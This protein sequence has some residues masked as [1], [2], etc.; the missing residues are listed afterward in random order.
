MRIFFNYTIHENKSRGIQG[1]N[2]KVFEILHI[3]INFIKCI[4]GYSFITLLPWCNAGTSN[5]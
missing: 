5:N 1:E 4:N 2:N 3:P